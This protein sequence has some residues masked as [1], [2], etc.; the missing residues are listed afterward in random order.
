MYDLFLYSLFYLNTYGLYIDYTLNRYT[1][2]HGQ[3]LES[4]YVW[5]IVEG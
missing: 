2:T 1:S 4:G 5:E 3:S